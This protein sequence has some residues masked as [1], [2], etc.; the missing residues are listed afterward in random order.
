M[1]LPAGYGRTVLETSRT[2]QLFQVTTV[3]PDQ[4]PP[5]AAVSGGALALDGSIENVYS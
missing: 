5:P 4:L 1:C 3:T 2:R